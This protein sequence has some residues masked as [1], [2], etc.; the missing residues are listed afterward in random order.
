M[1]KILVTLILSLSLLSAVPAKTIYAAGEITCTGGRFSVDTID[2]EDVFNNVACYA[3][4]DYQTAYN[5]MKEIAAS[6]PNVILTYYGDNPVTTAVVETNYKKIIAADRAMAYSLQYLYVNYTLVN[7][8]PV[9]DSVSTVTIYP[10]AGLNTGSS[11][12][13]MDSKNQ[14]FY[15]DTEIRSTSTIMTPANL[16]AKISVN[17]AFGYVALKTIQLIPLIYVDNGWTYDVDYTP[18]PESNYITKTIKMR[19]AYYEVVSST[20][21]TVTGSKTFNEIRIVTNYITTNDYVNTIGLAPDWLPIGKYYSPDGITFYR[22]VDLTQPVYN[23]ANIGKYF[24]YYQYLN[25]RSKTN[26]TASD[27]D[28]YIANIIK[29]YRSTMFNQ[30]STFIASQDQYGMNALVIYSMAAL[31]S[32]W[33]KSDFAQKPADLN[34]TQILDSVTFAPIVVNISVKT[35][36]AIYPDQTFYDA[37]HN[38]QSCS[39]PNLDDTVLTVYDNAGALVKITKPIEYCTQYPTGKFADQDH[40]IQLCSGR[41]NLFGWQS[42]DSSPLSAYAFP[43]IEACVSEHMGINLRRTYMNVYNG[44]FYA[45]NLGTKGAGFNTRYASDPWWGINIASVAYGIDRYYD[46][47]D[48]YSVQLGILKQSNPSNPASST[49]IYK[50]TALSTVFYN[51]PNRAANYPLVI[52]EGLVVNGNLIYKVQTSN[53]VDS[54]GTININEYS[55][56]SLVPYDYTVS[57]GY[58]DA[59]QISDYI[60][61]T[62][63]GVTDKGLYN[64]SKQ[65]FIMSGTAT[66]NGKPFTSGDLISAEGN[67]EIIATSA[68]G[69]VQKLT[70]TIDK[71]APVITFNNYQTNPT[72][73]DITVNAMINE[74]T[75]D[76]T[77]Y[78]F[79]EN[80]SYT[81][82]A[83]DLAGN[84]AERTVE[85]TNI[86]KIAPII[87]IGDFDAV[88]ISSTDITV[89]ATTN[90]GSLNADSHVFARNGSFDFIATDAAGNITTQTVTITNIVK[91]VVFTYATELAGGNLSAAIGATPLSSGSTVTSLDLVTVSVTLNPKYHV[92][93]WLVNDAF[94]LTHATTLNVE[95][96]YLNTT[97]SVEFYVEGDLND[98]SKMTTTDLVQLRRIIAGLDSGNEKAVL[99]ADMNGDGKVSTTDLVKIRRMLAGLE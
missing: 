66:L 16:S 7:N 58:I 45:S 12:P 14:L 23:G 95:Y 50:D 46:F 99:A 72:N 11:L 43:S 81:F 53:P 47:K 1:K 56:T 64:Q 97:V 26:L 93:R 19:Q 33:G 70:F 42:Y 71:T 39:D 79:T 37:S 60:S 67:Y 22:D 69:V 15:Y 41:Y 51:I 6:R 24:N 54:N 21:N 17:G 25:L 31:E 38:L 87:T 8:V 75:L 91:S 84:V 29:P 88:T 18:A 82:R 68:N 57:Y 80:G 20:V 94:V 78:T 62:I 30:G 10:T 3:L 44:N 48:L 65:V 85:I 32:G 2:G 98:D 73:Q 77:S 76:Q 55:V 35:Y 34:A 92:Y 96:P 90:E 63:V 74:G 52:M 36:C 61:K 27:F 28:T 89:T 13:Y 40:V 83:V 9:Y 59:D 5:K 4:T 86:D 49:P